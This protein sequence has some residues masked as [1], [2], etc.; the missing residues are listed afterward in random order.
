MTKGK[1]YQEIRFYPK[2]YEISAE[3]KRFLVAVTNDEVLQEKL[4]HTNAI[5]D[6]ASIGKQLGYKVMG[7]DIL[8]A[9]AGRA[10]A[11]LDEGTEDVAKIVSGVKPKTGLQWGR[12]GSG[13]LDRA[14]YWLDR[15]SS[16]QALTPTEET[17]N[18]FLA[19]SH[20]DAALRQQLFEV[21]H[22]DGLAKLMQLS[23]YDVQAVDLVSH[24]AQK[25]LALDVGQAE[26]MAKH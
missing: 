1:R 21:K 18:G 20:E 15:L 10:L 5:S 13:Y 4:C 19:K 24:Q 25:I 2:S 11:M 12:G 6:V 8:Q 17:I 23:G 3:L 14:G 16:Q 26:A 7:G 22:F 9:Q